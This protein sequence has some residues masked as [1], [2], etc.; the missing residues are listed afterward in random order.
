MEDPQSHGFQIF[1]NTRIQNGLSLDDLGYDLGYLFGIR[2]GSTG[3]GI[4]VA[5]VCAAVLCRP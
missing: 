4:P 5:Q 3:D 1:S 2:N